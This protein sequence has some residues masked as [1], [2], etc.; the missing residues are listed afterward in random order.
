MNDEH[1]NPINL[2]TAPPRMVDDVEED[3]P[4]VDEAIKQSDVMDHLE[5]A[6]EDIQ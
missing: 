1:N 2:A 6:T 5:K 4:L 3:I